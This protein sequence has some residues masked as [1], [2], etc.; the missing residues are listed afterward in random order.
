MG[1][2][3]YELNQDENF[4]AIIRKHPVSL[5]FPFF[6]AIISIAAAVAFSTGFADFQY[7]GIIVIAWIIASI[8]YGVY[9]IALWHLDCHIITDK[10]I[11]DIDQRNIFSRIVSEVCS[12]D[13]EEVI[14]EIKGIPATIFNYGTVK[15]KIANNG[16]TIG[17]ERISDPK[18][19]KDMIT[20]IRKTQ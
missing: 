6:G 12:C 11:V 2:L 13:M 4:L 15:I 5:A 14:Y 8:I 17:M 3:N 19:V 20:K 9:K 7:K 10:R 18:E 1:Y 16:G